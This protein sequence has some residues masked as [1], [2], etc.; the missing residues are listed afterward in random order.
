MQGAV[1][2]HLVAFISVLALVLVWFAMEGHYSKRLPFW[3]E[4][5]QILKIGTTGV[6][7]EGALLLLLSHALIDWKRLI[8]T[9]LGVFIL[10]P[11]GRSLGRRAMLLAGLYGRNVIIVG[12]GENAKAAYAA[13]AAEW[14][15]GYTVRWF[16][17]SRAEPP[18]S[19]LAPGQADTTLPVVDLSS[20]PV[21]V[22]RSLG[23]PR[24]IVA[25]DS[26]ARQDTFLLELGAA[27]TDVL[28]IPALRGLPLQGMEVSHFFSR[29]LVMLRV[30]NNLAQPGARLI[31]RVFDVVGSALLLVVTAP[32][33]L[34]IAWLVRRDGGDAIYGHVRI[35]EG[36]SAFECLKFRSMVV[37]ADRILVE[38]LEGDQSFRAKW[39]QQF[40]LKQDPRIT[41]IGAFLRIS[42]LDELPQLINVLKGDMSLVGPRPVVREELERYG[43]HIGCYLQ[44]KPGITGVWQVSG[45]NDVDYPTRVGFDA[46]YVRNWSLWTDIVVLL[47]TVRVVITRAGAY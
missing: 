38:L 4:L 18:C 25:L 40:K 14:S 10:L 5:R 1:S 21:S 43:E 41:R 16:G 11:V 2:S 24:I 6:L 37:D 23:N 29:E 46:W 26:L 36:G 15:M 35:G 28:V 19:E 45:R 13:L 3:D 34:A 42:S 44:V 22:L 39:E 8:L 9:W 12:T 32:L 30:R 33:F 7:T 31:K 17:R 27:S 47:K 20:D